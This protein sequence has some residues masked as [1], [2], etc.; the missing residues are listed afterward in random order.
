MIV[1]TAVML[2]LFQTASPQMQVD[3]T[4]LRADASEYPAPAYPASSIETRHT[5]R[6]IVAVKIAP[7]TNVSPLARVRAAKVVESPDPEMAEAVLKALKDARFMPFFDENGAVVEVSSRIVWNF[8][9]VDGRPQVVDPHAPPIERAAA[10][11]DN[12]LKI[13]R[14]ARQLLSSAEVWNRSDN[15]QCP[16][17]AKTIS[18]Y[19]A[20]EVAT[21]QVTGTF[22]HRGTAM[23]DVREVIEKQLAQR[24]YAHTLMGYNNDPATTFADLGRVFDLAERRIASRSTPV[25]RAPTK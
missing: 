3:E 10:L 24:E 13:V 6:V 16:P 11:A 20:L 25:P 23:D 15:R 18:L 12:D 7:A 5:G 1:L 2:A 4:A 19:C 17:R 22:E 14:A 21:Q 8:Q 9:L